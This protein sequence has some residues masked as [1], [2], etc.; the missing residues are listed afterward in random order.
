[1]LALDEFRV[2]RFN[3]YT[4]LKPFSYLNRCNPVPMVPDCF[5]LL[6][7]ARFL[8]NSQHCLKL[9]VT[10]PC[11][12]ALCLWQMQVMAKAGENHQNQHQLHLTDQKNHLK[13]SCKKSNVFSPFHLPLCSLPMWMTL[14]CQ[15]WHSL[16]WSW[17]TTKWT[18]RYYR[19]FGQ[20]VSVFLWLSLKGLPLKRSF[21]LVL[22]E[23][24][25]FE[26]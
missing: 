14:T 10:Q 25:L 6:S 8:E 9:K 5:F 22:F 2:S 17:G 3:N 1:M 4:D 15:G 16:L 11:S 24:F 19:S 23:F 21:W 26:V 18:S 20:K 13:E 7:L 12:F